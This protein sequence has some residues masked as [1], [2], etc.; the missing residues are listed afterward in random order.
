ML[1]GAAPDCAS[2]ESPISTQTSLST[3]PSAGRSD[4]RVRL[5]DAA[6]RLFAERG[7]DGTSMRALAEAAELQKN[8]P[9]LLEM[10]ESL[11]AWTAEHRQQWQRAQAE[12]I[13]ERVLTRWGKRA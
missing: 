2:P 3:A 5:L 12:Y 9:G 6:E 8:A 7:F 11:A 10:V 4:T 1:P 13:R